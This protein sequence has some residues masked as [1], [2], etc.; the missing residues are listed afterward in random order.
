MR[1]FAKQPQ[2]LFIKNLKLLIHLLYFLS[3]PTFHKYVILSNNPY[4]L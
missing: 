3:A 2:Y 4:Y 1:H